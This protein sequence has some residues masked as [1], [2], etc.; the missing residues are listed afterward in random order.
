MQWCDEGIILSTRRHG[1]SSVI[2]DLLT[3]HYG[4]HA[5]MVR[6]GRSKRYRPILQQGNR[7]AA[8]WKARLPEHLGMYVLE[9]LHLRTALIMDEPLKLLALQS[10]CA[11]AGLVAEREPHEGLFE[12]T[13][14]MIKALVDE[15][16]WLPMLVQWEL[17]LLAELGFGLDLTSCAATGSTDELVY[18]S[19]K[20]SRAVSRQAGQPYHE[21]LLPLP[22]FLVEKSELP[23]STI[24]VK[25]GLK[26]TGFFLQQYF[27]EH[28]K[29]DLPEIR[30]RLYSNI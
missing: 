24:E 11:L 16:Q 20:S 6:G 25:S 30:R 14:V 17:G 28:S 27:D 26:L 22:L 15:E 8:D 7:V 2:V 5:G 19:P 23:I 1:E 4:R 13:E 21:Q 18:V 12:A 9:P 29:Q 10:V 3:R